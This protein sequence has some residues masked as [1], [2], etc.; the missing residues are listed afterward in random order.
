[1]DRYTRWSGLLDLLARRER[2]TVEEAAGE[3]G[4][5]AA[6]VRRDF[7]ALAAQRKL[8]RLR[9]AAVQRTRAD[10]ITAGAVGPLLGIRARCRRA[11]LAGHGGICVGLLHV[12]HRNRSNKGAR[13]GARR[14]SPDNS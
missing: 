4:V 7:E 12:A 14:A 8:L 11:R 2:M 5:S 3:L 9:G 6:T 10:G 1:M 13:A